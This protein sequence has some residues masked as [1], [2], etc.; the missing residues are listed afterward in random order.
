MMD[1]RDW[2]GVLDRRRSGF[3]RGRSLYGG[4]HKRS[5]EEWGAKFMRISWAQPK[6]LHK[7]HRVCSRRR[8][9]CLE[10]S[11]F[12]YLKESLMGLGGE[13]HHWIT[14]LPR[15]KREIILRRLRY[16]CFENFFKESRKIP[17]ER[18]ERV[19]VVPW[20]GLCLLISA[21]ALT[22]WAS[23]VE[24]KARQSR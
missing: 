6:S 18:T 2:E 22:A 12:Y 14:P 17:M 11:R 7:R 4:F 24:P 3:E 10:W 19:R 20:R 1:I 21:K 23:S 5:G 8:A 9:F 13:R 16:A 15:D